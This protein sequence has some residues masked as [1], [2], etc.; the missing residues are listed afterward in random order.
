MSVKLK[1]APLTGKGFSV[2]HVYRSNGP[3]D[4][5]A[6]LPQPI[7]AL[8]DDTVEYQDD[9]YPPN[10]VVNYLIGGVAED[11]TI[12]AG[13]QI[14]HGTFTDT[15]PGNPAP[16]RGDWNYGYFGAV[17][18]VDFVTSTMLF[19]GG[20]V[21]SPGAV[22]RWHKLIWNGKIYFVPETAVGM[23][24][25]SEVYK[26][27]MMYEDA[28][29]DVRPKNVNGQGGDFVKQDKHIAVGNW[30]FDVH[31]PRINTASPAVFTA[32]GLTDDSEAVWLFYSMA[33]RGTK[34]AKVK[35]MLNDMPTSALM[36]ANFGNSTYSV[37]IDAVGTTSN[38]NAT[39]AR[40]WLPML[41]LLP[42]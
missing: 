11:G 26:A 40:S 5:T 32:A 6:E 34:Q 28:L 8:T 38:H 10:A 25:P 23:C 39:T 7:G 42:Q 1:W 2:I 29:G 31:T 20:L 16:I 33:C 21:G 9:G 3:I 18:A 19:A 13:V 4:L 22:A 14:T 24:S 37:G 36:T 17:D 27:G 30:L 41:E 12:N 35:I 15:G